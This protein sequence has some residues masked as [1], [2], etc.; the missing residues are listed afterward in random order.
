MGG[1][2][3]S[4]EGILY[5]DLENIGIV[6]YDLHT[7]TFAATQ[8]LTDATAFGE[9][10]DGFWYANGGPAAP[11]DLYRMLPEDPGFPLRYVG[12]GA[13]AMEDIATSPEGT[14]FGVG[15][16]WV[17]TIDRETGD[18]TDLFA[19]GYESK[20][21]GF[22]N[23]GK[24]LAADGRSLYEVDPSTGE[25]AFWNEFDWNIVDLG[26]ESGEPTAIESPMGAAERHLPRARRGGRQ[27]RP[28]EVDSPQVVNCRSNERNSKSPASSRRPGFP[29]RP[30]LTRA[31]FRAP[32]RSS[33]IRKSDGAEP[34]A[35]I[36]PLE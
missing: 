31:G 24:M 8:V 34:V 3:G 10:G 25:S 20:G 26:S 21:L 6:R 35:Q 28:E 13:R 12:T 14:T 1:G 22:T 29:V 9:G 5:I 4:Q 2:G 17:F 32:D 16:G 15:E 23:E 18:Q 30:R 36:P 27:Q 19:L 11:R 7:F 33:R